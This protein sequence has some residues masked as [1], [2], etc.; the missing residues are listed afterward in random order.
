MTVRTFNSNCF[1][2]GFSYDEKPNPELPGT[3]FWE[4]DTKDLYI[5]TGSEWVLRDVNIQS[6]ISTE[7]GERKLAVHDH[8][9]IC[10]LEEMIDLLKFTNLHL[11]SLTEEIFT[12]EDKKC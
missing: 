7:G 4:E 3:T 6:L 9:V 10:L 8:E 1:F 12:D 2:T 5:W 11:Q